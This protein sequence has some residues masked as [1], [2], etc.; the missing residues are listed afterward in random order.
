MVGTSIELTNLKVPTPAA[1]GV[2]VV[3]PV[4]VIWDQILNPSPDPIDSFSGLD[5]TV[6]SGSTRSKCGDSD[7]QNSRN[8]FRAKKGYRHYGHVGVAFVIAPWNFPVAILCGMASAV[9]RY[10][11]RRGS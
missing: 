3:H 7:A 5:E 8:R 10:R 9:S 4:F 6:F 1:T 11:K 2:H